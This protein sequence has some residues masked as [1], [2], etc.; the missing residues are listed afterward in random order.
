MATLTATTIPTREEYDRMAYEYMASLPPEHFME[1]SD[2]AR[3]RD[4]TVASFD[5][6]ASERP[7]I[8]LFSELLVQY[9]RPGQR[10]NGQVVPDNMVI[11]DSKKISSLISFTVAH[12]G[13]R[14]FMVLEYVSPSAESQRKDYEDSYLKYERELRIPYYLIFDL[15]EQKLEVFRHNGQIYE[16]VK[17][18]SKGRYAIPELETDVALEDEWVRY[19]F[20][21]QLQPVTRELNS[22]LKAERQK[23]K[24]LE[25]ENQR[26]RD[27]LARSNLPTI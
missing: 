4:I 19:W 23:V 24:G 7:D 5:C 2:H 13:T 27:L 25:A 1:R 14:P 22:E 12:E 21:G 18:D 11:V 3:Q 20:R 8:Q 26:L 9:P 15:E 10:R 6:I 17:A 16:A